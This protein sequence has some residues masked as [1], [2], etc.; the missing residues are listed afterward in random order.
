MIK[1]KILIIAA[2]PDDEILGAGGTLIKHTE[3]GDDVFCLI[4]GEGAMS[5]AGAVRSEIKKLQQQTSRAGKIIGFKKIYF[6]NLPD[7]SFDTVVLLKIVK[8][9][10][11][12]LKKIEPD[13]VYTHYGHDLNIDHQLTFEAVLTACRPCNSV[14]PK[15][16]FVFETLSSS[17]WQAS[18]KKFNP[19]VYIDIEEVFDK[20]I[21]A[22]KEYS[23]EIKKYPHPRSPEGIRILAQYRGLE[24]GLRFAEAFILERRIE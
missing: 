8:I 6:S 5:R 24:S 13:I 10:E 9:I 18:D 21:A 3:K 20:K 7:N 16:I 19:N 2:H 17:E 11:G 4:L 15:E 22:M 23:S 1:K 12:Y 14:S